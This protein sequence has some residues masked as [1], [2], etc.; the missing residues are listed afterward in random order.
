M[1]KGGHLYR[2]P[3][4]SPAVSTE[5][6][7][8]LW[9]IGELFGSASQHELPYPIDLR[10]YEP[11]FSVI[12][13]SDDFIVVDKPAHLVV[14]PTTPN[15]PPT[16]LDGLESL[17][18]YELANG[19]QLSIITRL[20]RET[21][22]VVLVAKHR[23]A[24]R[25]FGI[26]MSRGE[27]EKRYLA[28]T[29]GWPGEDAFEIDAPLRRRGE[30]EPSPIWVKQAVHPEGRACHT[31][32]TVRRRFERD[33]TRFSL[34]ECRPKTGRMHQIRA[35]LHHAGFPLVGDK[36]YGPD[37]AC[38]LEFIETGWTSSLA[39]RLL[40]DRQALHASELAWK[41]NRWQCP[42]PSSL[43]LLTGETS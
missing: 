21:S 18:V 10:L 15:Q 6:R 35:H 1:K 33:G 8:R 40:L 37:E 16:L 12:A 13:E 19:G 7:E 38:Y 42:L 30:F 25:E 41:A 4:R 5:G 36:L 11:E 14:H 34:L 9:W 3:A 23:E 20:D 22:G 24:A 32:V 2:N 43:T 26:A 28:V 31:D 17:L 27:F 39:R 29:W